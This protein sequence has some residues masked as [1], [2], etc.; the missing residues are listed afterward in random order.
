M[1][2]LSHLQFLGFDAVHQRVFAHAHKQVGVAEPL[3]GLLDVRDRS[4]R[5][6]EI[7][8]SFGSFVTC[9][10]H[11]LRAVRGSRAEIVWDGRL[12]KSRYKLK[13]IVCGAALVY[14]SQNKFQAHLLCC[15]LTINPKHINYTPS[16]PK[17]PKFPTLIPIYTSIQ[18]NNHPTGRLSSPSPL[19]PPTGAYLGVQVVCQQTGEAALDRVLVGEQRQ[20]VRQLVLRGDDGAVAGPVEL[21]SSGAAE[22]LHHVQHA[23]VHEG[24]VLGVV[25]VGALR[26]G[27]AER[28]REAVSDP[29]AMENSG[30]QKC[31]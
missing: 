27:G 24:A 14:T 20:I 17:S 23:Q 18:E 1:T 5:H 7:G 26:R 10:L 16:I 11:Q 15:L 8:E 19:P 25:D 2:S 4:Q 3:N 22:Y 12:K 31:S 21:R 13:R 6:L 9:G 30:R 28:V 29:G